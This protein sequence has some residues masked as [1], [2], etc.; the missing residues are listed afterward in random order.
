MAGPADKSGTVTAPAPNNGAKDN[1]P[2]LDRPL[3][4][5]LDT[6]LDFDQ[7]LPRLRVCERSAREWT[8]QGLIPSIRLPGSRRV[9]YH[10]PSVERALLRLQRGGD[11]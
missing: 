10:W 7:L 11:V 5:I 3:P 9:L 4:V 1:E 6:F 2:D 8:R